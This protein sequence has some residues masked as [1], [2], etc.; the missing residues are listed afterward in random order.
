MYVIADANQET[1]Y[2]LKRVL[3]NGFATI[4]VDMSEALLFKRRS[5]AQEAFDKISSTSMDFKV[6]ALIVK[7]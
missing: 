6:H 1:I 7:R 4:T 3:S 2:Y 5:E